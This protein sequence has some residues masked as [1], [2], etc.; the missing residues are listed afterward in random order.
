[1]RMMD[2]SN[3]P[4]PEPRLWVRFDDGTWSAFRGAIL[5]ASGLPT[6]TAAWDLIDRHALPPRPPATRPTRP[7]DHHEAGRARETPSNSTHVRWGRGG[8][9]PGQHTWEARRAV[10]VNALPAYCSMVVPR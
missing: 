5:L 9:P 8:S 6:V 2:E 3:I 7:A 4:R 1:M 10:V